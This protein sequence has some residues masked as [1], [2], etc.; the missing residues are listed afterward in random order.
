M[1]SK[2][3]DAESRLRDTESK[4]R[5][6]E[7]KASSAQAELAA[8]K[9]E[10]DSLQRVGCCLL[11][12]LLLLLLPCN[13]AHGSGRIPIIAPSSVNDQKPSTFHGHLA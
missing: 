10:R 3:R 5:D 7:S 13:S 2:L 8:M 11:L 4:L 6:A 1:E 9:A 12:L